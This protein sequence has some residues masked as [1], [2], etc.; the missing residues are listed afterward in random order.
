ML[1]LILVPLLKK[2]SILFLEQLIPPFFIKVCAKV[3]EIL[4]SHYATLE[5]A[6]RCS[7]NSISSQLYTKKI[8]TKEAR[9]SLNYSK[10][11][12]EFEAK[13]PLLNNV[14]ELK[15]HC[16]VFL[17]CISQGGP[18][19]DAARSLSI[20]WGQV[21]DMYSLIPIPISMMPSTQLTQSSSPV[22]NTGSTGT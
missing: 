20:E 19:D 16:Q 21:F 15:R 10:M 6:T 12:Q 2:V 14:S 13:L 11:M 7:L 1:N 5:E 3:K 8:I 22:S 18:T 17:E 4:R 9:D